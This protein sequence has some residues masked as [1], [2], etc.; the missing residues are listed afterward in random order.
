MNSDS[1]SQRLTLHISFK[2]HYHWGLIL[3]TLPYL[4]WEIYWAHEVGY[5][6]IKW[7]TRLMIYVYLWIFVYLFSYYILRP[8][9]RQRHQ[10]LITVFT[11]IAVVLFI[12]EL[13]LSAF[14]VNETVMEKAG[15][16]YTSYYQVGNESP[17][18]AYPPNKQH[19]ITKP[20]YRYSRM[21]NSLGFSDMEWPVNKKNNE[22]RLLALGDSFTEG[23]GAP[24]DSSYVA[25]LRG[26]F[27]SDSTIYIMNAGICGSD[28]FMNFASYHDRLNT[29]HPDIVLQTLSSGDMNVDMMVRGG[30]ERFLSNGKVQ[31]KRAPR[32]EPVYALSFISRLCFTALGYDQLLLKK[33]DV[34]NCK[35]EL[36]GKVVGLFKT[37]A[38]LT[39]KN[40]CKLLVILQPFLF[41]V[42]EKKY[43]YDF[44]A[45][46]SK[47]KGTPNILVV[48]LMPFYNKRIESA[49]KTPGYYYWK[50]DGHHNPDGYKMMA[51]GIYKGL[52]L[53]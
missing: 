13:L 52:V 39:Q 12:T 14:G 4:F 41:E 28:P 8:I 49:N 21:S 38:S 31:F 33:T 25:L 16:G 15:A 36:D 18:H 37:Y 51:D 40:N 11:A 3:I 9:G 43:G 2:L 5:A 46:L 22:K 10:R 19:W 29:Y 30:M 1:I 48:D 27:S 7:H 47:L 35:N 6:C 45:I 44:S 42:K 23:D 34:D 24:Y 17:Y 32:W 50:R 53:K 26:K 20:E